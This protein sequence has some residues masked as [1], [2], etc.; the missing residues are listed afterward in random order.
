MRLAALALALTATLAQASPE[1]GWCATGSPTC[2]TLTVAYSTDPLFGA[3][4]ETAEVPCSDGEEC[5]VWESLPTPAAGAVYFVLPR[6]CN[7]AG[8]SPLREETP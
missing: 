7:A 8:C 1:S 4:Q 5:T 6:C 3:W 2:E